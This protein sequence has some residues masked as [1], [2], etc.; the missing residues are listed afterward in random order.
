DSRRMV[1][2][3]LAPGSDGV[4]TEQLFTIELA[5]GDRR[6]VTHLTAGEP[7]KRAGKIIDYFLFDRAD[8]IAFVHVTGEKRES[9][10]IEIDGTGLRPEGILPGLAGTGGTEVTQIV[11]RGGLAFGVAGVSFPGPSVNADV[12]P[13]FGP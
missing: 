9:K 8:R 10:L 6:Q 5:T 7:P 11:R 13:D 1:F 4:E 3:D 12:L 2:T